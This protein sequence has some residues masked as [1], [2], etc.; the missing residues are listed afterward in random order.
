MKTDGL[1]NVIVTRLIEERGRCSVELS[2]EF[3]L[4]DRKAREKE[5][6]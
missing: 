2:G 5:G 3:G 4:T 1:K 6:W